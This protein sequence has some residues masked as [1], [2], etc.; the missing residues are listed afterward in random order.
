MG[1]MMKWLKATLKGIN[2][3]QL[4]ADLFARVTFSV[5]TGMVIE[6]LIAGMTVQQSLLSRATNLPLVMLMARPYG[7]YRDWAVK[8]CNAPKAERL[9]RWA[10]V[11]TVTYTTFFVPQYALVLWLEGSTRMQILKA[12]GTVALFSVLL[13]VVFGLWLDLIR[14]RL[15]RIK[16]SG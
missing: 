15:F 4:A 9:A 6:I 11:N 2:W 5:S 16:K 7:I 3:R 8:K 14:H 12:S 10:L 1:K 13:G